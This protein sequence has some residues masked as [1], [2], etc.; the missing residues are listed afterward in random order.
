[1][2]SPVVL[3]T[4]DVAN[5]NNESPN[6]KEKEELKQADMARRET[7]D[8]GSEAANDQSLVVNREDI[9]DCEMM[10]QIP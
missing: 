6:N 5:S 10:E 8:A 4:S 7:N 2:R 9:S 1:M 3:E